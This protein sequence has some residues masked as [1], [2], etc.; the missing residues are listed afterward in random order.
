MVSTLNLAHA[1]PSSG[2][3]AGPVYCQNDLFPGNSRLNHS[4]AHIF[5]VTGGTTPFRFSTYVGDVGDTLIVWPAG[6][7]KSVFLNTAEAQFRRYEDAQVYIFDKGGSSRIV[8]DNVG[9][10]FYDPGRV[11]SP[12]FQPLAETGCSLVK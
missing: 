8:T 1:M 12:A 11:G 10:T 5:A 3:W 4:P 9:G 6:A 7:G 2:V